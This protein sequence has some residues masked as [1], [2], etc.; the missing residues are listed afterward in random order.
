MSGCFIGCDAST[1]VQSEERAV[2]DGLRDSEWTASAEEWC[3]LE[4]GHAGPHAASAA[5]GNDGTGG[6]LAWWWL[7][8]IGDQRHLGPGP[9]CAARAGDR[10]RVD[11][12]HCQL[13]AGHVGR[14]TYEWERTPAT[15]HLD[16]YMLDFRVLEA[17]AGVE[18]PPVV[19]V[20]ALGTE[21]ATW[22]RVVNRLAPGPRMLTYNRAGIG[23]STPRPPRQRAATYGD[24]AAELV[25][26]L[27]LLGITQPIVLVG[28]SIGS[29]IVR[30]LAARWPDRVAGMV[31]VDGTIPVI[32]GADEIDWLDGDGDKA[33]WIDHAA[34]TAEINA[35]TTYPQVPGVVLV[36]TPGRWPNPPI[37]DLDERWSA[38]EQL[39]AE[40][41]GAVRIDAVDAGH[42]LQDEVPDLVALAIRSVL[43]A[44]QHDTP[45]TLDPD[46]VAAAAGSLNGPRQL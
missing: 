9:V 34:G 28:H 3:E 27:D 40:Q 15:A 8:W 19:F 13:P 24:F 1:R 17:A 43:H 35:I 36:K 2:L 12:G 46:A 5:R 14:H 39:L 31:H 21:M 4:P 44:A 32:V 25:A 11:N 22:A 16:G 10:F 42:H 45:V 29:L 18:G 7:Y 41:I 6:A 20:N 30:I 38:A 33:T 26:L 23:G 37:P